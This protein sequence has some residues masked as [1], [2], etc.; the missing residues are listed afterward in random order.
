[1][2]PANELKTGWLS[3]SGEFTPCSYYEHYSTARVIAAALQVPS[4]DFKKERRIDEEQAI[5]DAGY[6]LVGRS[7]VFF[8]GW[9]IEWSLYH[10]LTPEQRQFLEP[11][12]QDASQIEEMTM[13]RW[14]DEL[15]TEYT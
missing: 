9:R 4:Y 14:K 10:T 8:H 12:F 11:Y 6:V 3:P 1:M 7:T 5:I 13:M 15:W 2:T